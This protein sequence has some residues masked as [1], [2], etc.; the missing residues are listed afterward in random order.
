MKSLSK[1]QIP[2]TIMYFRTVDGVFKINTI[3]GE[4]GD[5]CIDLNGTDTICTTQYLDPTSSQPYEYLTKFKLS[6]D[7]RK[8]DDCYFFMTLYNANL[9]Y[10]DPGN[11]G[12]RIVEYDYETCH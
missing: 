8:V 10:Y 1:T 3:V 9:E 5:I 2:M 11:D 12:E 7:I 4:N 6:F